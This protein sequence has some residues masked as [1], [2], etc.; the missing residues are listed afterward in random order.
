MNPPSIQ[1]MIEIGVKVEKDIFE[2]SADKVCLAMRDVPSMP[3]NTRRIY[4]K[5]SYNRRWDCSLSSATRT[6]LA[7]SSRSTSKRR[8]R[9][10]CRLKSRLRLRLRLRLR[11]TPKPRHK[12]RHSK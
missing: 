6:R 5:R 12:C 2:K 7:F 10:S 9:P 3:A 11:H 1:K 8:R 4:T